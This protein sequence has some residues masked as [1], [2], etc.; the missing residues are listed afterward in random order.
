MNKEEAIEYL[1]KYKYDN[2][3]RQAIETVLNYIEELEKKNK[4]L[5]EN[6]CPK[7]KQLETEKQYYFEKYQ[8]F[9]KQNDSLTREFSYVIPKQKIRDKI[10]E[11]ENK[12]ISSLP[13][14]YI[15]L[16][17][18]NVLKEILGEDEK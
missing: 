15:Q 6:Y 14:C 10:E 9:L 2:E 8:Y 18:I 16:S 13:G 4:D 3:V 12:F 1:K 7:Y 17:K 11:L 5:C